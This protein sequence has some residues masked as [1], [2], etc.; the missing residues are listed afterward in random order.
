MMFSVSPSV[1][2]LFPDISIAVVQGTVEAARPDLAQAIAALRQ[3]ALIQLRQSGVD[4][5]NLPSHP[6]VLAW[7]NAYQLFGVKPKKHT[8]THE[9]FARRLLKEGSWPQINPIVDIY[10]TNQLAHLLPH[11]GYDQTQLAGNLQLSQCPA[12]E[13][14]EPLGGGEETT[15]VGEVVYRDDLRILTRRWNYRDCDAAKVTESTSCFLLMI[16]A[17][18]QD[19]PSEAIERAGKDLVARYQRCFEGDFKSSVLRVAPETHTF[20]L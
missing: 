15:E 12:P 20:T 5:T 8:P 19:I 9:A 6:H 11:G 14:F 2:A 7:R 10:L 4:A 13:R 1:L 16:E 17:P 3:E 18:S